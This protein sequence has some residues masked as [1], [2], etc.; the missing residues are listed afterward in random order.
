MTLH[1]LLEGKE[2]FY[3]QFMVPK[4]PAIPRGSAETLGVHREEQ[5]KGNSI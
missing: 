5:E 1:V 4:L 2:K 3:L